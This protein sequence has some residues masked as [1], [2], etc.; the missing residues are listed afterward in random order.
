MCF[1]LFNVLLFTCQKDDFEN[2]GQNES[3]NI[4]HKVKGISLNEFQ[5]NSKL[6]KPLK[7]I[8]KFFDIKK[9]KSK[10]K[11]S[12]SNSNIDSN[13][14]IDANNG[15]FTILTD[16]II[17]VTTDSTATYSFLIENPT[18]F[19][20][21]FENFVIEIKHDSLINYYILRYNLKNELND[22]FPYD[23]TLEVLDES[24][25]DSGIILNELN[26]KK[27]Y[28][29]LGNCIFMFEDCA[30]PDGM[31][32]ISA[33]C[34]G[35]SGGT[36]TGG[37][38]D[39]ENTGS[40]EN[41]EGGGSGGG[42][43]PPKPDE[44]IEMSDYA[45]VQ[46]SPKLDVLK[47]L[48]EDSLTAEQVNWINHPDNEYAVK[49]MA[50]M[51]KKAGCAAMI[52]IIL[53]YID[54]SPPITQDFRDYAYEQLECYGIQELMNSVYFTSALNNLRGYAPGASSEKGYEISRNSLGNISNNFVEGVSG[55]VTLRHGGEI[56]GGMHI[57]HDPGELMFSAE[58]IYNLYQYHTGSIVNNPNQFSSYE[59]FTILVTIHGTYMLK[60]KDKS[61]LGY[62]FQNKSLLDINGNL[63][64]YYNLPSTSIN[65]DDRFIKGLLKTF[66]YYK[67][68]MGMPRV[69]IN[70]YKLDE[71]TQEFDRLTLNSSDIIIKTP[72]N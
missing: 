35:S 7:K 17:E 37:T 6:Q 41:P 26:S 38:G 25:I 69:P 62:I 18:D 51:I 63:G 9:T 1:L 66:D 31:V 8:S 44:T 72:C 54:A 45:I 2:Q 22:E 61:L 11:A 64:F 33:W 60:M 39:G 67:R 40:G 52:D 43:T 42:G 58:D 46:P 32:F 19:T 12:N 28:F 30:C 14:K 13:S 21:E 36:G 5:Q 15:S 68:K 55:Y 50:H 59:V 4:G 49:G 71:S 16:Q 3:Q 53:D 10:N 20:S 29:T 34:L 27:V 48:I 24:I 23:I 47:C 57:H 70:F 56:M 65:E